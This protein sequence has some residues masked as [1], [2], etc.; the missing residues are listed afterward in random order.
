MTFSANFIKC[1]PWTNEPRRILPFGGSLLQPGNH[2]WGLIAD[3][4]TTEEIKYS[5]D[6]APPPTPHT[7][8]YQWQN[9][10]PHGDR[11]IGAAVEALLIGVAIY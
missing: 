8:N 11:S 1:Y 7:K 3:R 5:R 10:A 2:Y 6:R 9:S 4:P